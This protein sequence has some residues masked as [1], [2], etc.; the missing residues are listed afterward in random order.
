MMPRPRLQEELAYHPPMLKKVVS[1]AE[2]VLQAVLVAV[3]GTGFGIG[4]G[5]FLAGRTLPS[6]AS[7]AMGPDAGAAPA[8]QTASVAAAGTTQTKTTIE[9]KPQAA[10]VVSAVNTAPAGTQTA[11]TERLG[12]EKTGKVAARPLASEIHQPRLIRAS[13]TGVRTGFRHRHGLRHRTAH[14]SIAHSIPKA[15]PLVEEAKLE[16]PDERFRFTIEGD[17]TAVSY[18]VQSGVVSTDGPGMF[19]VEKVPGEVP[20]VHPQETPSNIHYKCDQDDNCSLTMANMVVPHARLRSVTNTNEFA[21]APVPTGP[22]TQDGTQS[23]VSL[24][25]VSR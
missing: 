5:V 14:S 10:Q 2:K 24:G 18:D 22:Q 17:D 8:T 4:V 23:P 7:A 15:E 11:T 9:A 6:D 12:A 25:Q 20:T 1:P 3:V 19:V 21:Y 13:L 16:I